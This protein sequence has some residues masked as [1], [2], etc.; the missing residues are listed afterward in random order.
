[1]SFTPGTNNDAVFV[2]TS[3][4]IIGAGLGNDWYYLSAA[5][6]E[7]GKTVQVSDAQGVNTIQIPAGFSIVGSRV[8]AD[9]LELTLN[10]GAKIQVF[11]ASSFTYV[12]GGA[13]LSSADATSYTFA[14]FVQ[15]ALGSTLPAAGQ[16]PVVNTA[17]VTVNNDGTTTAGPAP[18]P[19]TTFSLTASADSVNED[20]S[21]T[22]TVTASKA[23]TEATNVVFTLIPGSTTAAD[24]GTATTNL[25]DFGQGAFNPVTVSIPVGGTTATFTIT[26]PND[27]KTEL[28]ES[29]SVQAV[30][31]GTTLTKT[32]TLLDG[33]SGGGKTY[34][35]TKDQDIIAGT[36]GNDTVNG[37][38]NL[39]ASVA[40]ASTTFNG[41][42]QIS[43]GA[44][45]N[46][47][48]LAVSG[49]MTGGTPYTASL[50]NIEKIQVVEINNTATGDTV[51]V[52]AS[53]VADLTDL[54]V[55]KSTSAIEL[56]GS[57]TQNIT[58]A[59]TADAITVKGGKDVT[60]TDSTAAKNIVVSNSGATGNAVG[61][62]TVTDSKQTSGTITVDGGTTVNVTATTDKAASGNI[63]VGA[64]KAASGAVTVTQNVTND[65]AAAITAGN[66]AVTGGSTVT[67][68]KNLTNTATK[69]SGAANNITAGTVTVTGDSKTTA[70]TVNQVNVANDYAAVT[71][72]ATAETSAITFASLKSGEKIAISAGALSAL[73][74]D[75]TFTA[76]KDL[77]A[78]E[79][80]AAFANLINGDKQ[81]AGGKVANGI[82]T[83]A[84]D[85][86]WT[87]GAA[88]G[89]TV[90]FTATTTGNQTNE[91]TLTVKK[92]DG[93]TNVDNLAD[94]KT[95]K[96]DG[97]A[98][99]STTARDVTATMD[100]VT[101]NDNATAAITD[102]TVNGY[103][104]LNIGTTQE[105][106]KLANVSL[107]NSGGT[108]TID[109]AAGITSLNLTVNNVNNAVDI[110]TNSSAV[111][112]LAVTATGA[113]STFGLTAA[114]VETLTVAGDKVLDIDT[115]STLT[116]LKTVTVTG[117][118]GL[119]ID[120]SGANVTSV[121]TTGTTGAVTAT[122][123]ASKAT[124]TGGEGVD[125]VT[126]TNAAVAKNIALGGGNDTLD[127]SATSAAN[128][129]GT[130]TFDG[131]TG[132]NTLALAAADAVALSGATTFEGKISNFQKLSLT[133]ATATGTVDL[134]NMDDINYVISAGSDPTL[135]VGRNET[136][137][138]TFT[139]LVAGQKI[140]IDGVTLTAIADVTDI[141]V[142][143]AFDNDA[144]VSG[145]KFVISGTDGGAW[146]G[147]DN[148]GSA[149][150]TFTS[151]TAKT[152][153]GNLVPTVGN[154][155][156]G[157]NATATTGVAT[158]GNAVTSQEEKVAFTFTGAALA[159]GQQISFGGLTLTANAAM[160]AAEIANEFAVA[161]SV[162]GASTNGKAVTSGSWAPITTNFTTPTWTCVGEV[163]TVENT[164]A[165]N[166]DST[167]TAAMAIT[168]PAA[169]ATPA[170]LAVTTTDGAT[171]AEAA[172]PMLTLNNM[173]N[174]GTVELNAASD[175][176]GV[177]VKVTDAATN[178]ADVLNV[179]TSNQNGAKVNLGYVAA[180]GVETINV[181]TND[182]FVDADANGV[183]D[184]NSSVKLGLSSDKVTKATVTGAG[185]IELVSTS[186]TLAEVD[187]ST[188]EGILTFTAS[189]NSLVVKGGT[190]ADSLTA[191]AND[192][193]LYGNGGGDTLTVAGGLRVNLYGGD[194]ADTFVINNTA[195]TSLDAYAVING[196]A[197]GDT[198]KFGDAN[199]FSV[200]KIAL[201]VGADETL[202]N[203]ANQATKLLAEN[204]MGWFQRGGNTYIVLDQT[205]GAAGAG[206]AADT[207]DGG[208]D[209]VIMITG[210]VDL[211]TASYNSGSNTLEIA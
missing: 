209:Q 111:K 184:A 58:T 195:S 82:W 75:L 16:A 46:T 57:D 34:V 68:N 101:I 62:I 162:V 86:G 123:D 159:V 89:S 125:T 138:V 191:N 104:T 11:G 204:E 151:A 8:G 183:D 51:K 143:E 90:T 35:L 158:D 50:A 85:A 116:A 197:S 194:G 164:G 15:T 5:A 155:G 38:V 153:V 149:K 178:T 177:V 66:I 28:A 105:L 30:V 98:G 39:A 31:A 63:T 7:A 127:A 193:A 67:V 40:D 201:S 130:F 48:K 54:K 37:L 208:T 99:T 181:T 55:T 100:A 6:L 188:L 119:S 205:A 25:N 121:T 182:T 83:G 80:A 17:T 20:G 97:S 69:D 64:N 27:D 202:L 96:V 160:T 108:A 157:T 42:D 52:D 211:S 60:V 161:A 117:S 112:T 88:S 171:D 114:N 53:A 176:A 128:L 110:S 79:V 43:G 71:T 49:A 84:L 199:K 170:A 198:I 152:N 148:A 1:M 180:N 2:G 4:S 47:F 190:A 70:V 44:G 144:G 210:L 206:G 3:K 29:F 187:A 78:A 196:V 141:E 115:G 41:F 189:V 172:V 13:P 165:A 21:V 135:A 9:L 32:A 65:A 106:T 139:N 76:G 59:G 200:T 118:A 192:V 134:A 107:A 61:A 18:E 113:N 145:A 150:V 92:A 56:T 109:G 154:V 175:N 169:A 73:D 140:T 45:V 146:G 77:T 103:G 179:V 93:T 167:A 147:A 174:N 129:G 122:I 91:I 203:Y 120:A 132:T 163:L 142:A 87:S 10:N 22:Y 102:V 81:T 137:E 74:T 26:P 72:G 126:L 12:L 23:V 24:Q 133:K 33:T 124:Y 131:G 185:D 166:I 94:F 156:Q 168:L 186:S 36:A 95:N 136:A 173:A 207:F 14:N 19:A